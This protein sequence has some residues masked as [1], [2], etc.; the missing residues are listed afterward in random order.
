MQRMALRGRKLSK[1]SEKTSQGYKLDK[2]FVNLRARASSRLSSI[3]NLPHRNGLHAAAR[4]GFALHQSQAAETGVT[5]AG[6]D[7]VVVNRDAQRLGCGNDLAGHLDI[8]A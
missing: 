8:G 1:C 2:I 5:I 4:T 7:D 3:E 6:D